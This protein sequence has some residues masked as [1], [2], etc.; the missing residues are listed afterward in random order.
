MNAPTLAGTFDELGW[1]DWGRRFLIKVDEDEDSGCWLWTSTLVRG[2]GKFY[3]DGTT[4]PAHRVLWQYVHT[5]LPIRVQLDHLCRVRHCVCPSHLEAVSPR[6]NTLR[7]PDTVA[8]RHA[9]RT[10]CDHGH[11]FTP[12][13][14][15]WRNDGNRP[16]RKCRTCRQQ[17]SA[18]SKARRRAEVSVP[19]ATVRRV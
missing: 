15:L 2:Y 8:A 6:T 18:R 12:G 19:S 16:Y 9:V 13:N 14:T 10:H 7:S 11:E 5:A 4:H 1:P 17:I 3:L